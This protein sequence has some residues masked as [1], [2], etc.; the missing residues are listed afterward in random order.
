MPSSNRSGTSSDDGSSFTGARVSSQ[1]GRGGQDTAVRPRN[2]YGEQVKKSASQR[3]DVDRRVCGQVHAVHCQ[4]RPP[5]APARRCGPRAARVPIRLEAPVTATSFV[6]SVSTS[7]T[8]LAVSSR[9]AGLKAARSGSDRLGGAHPG[10]TVVV[11]A[12]NRRLRRPDPGPPRP[13]CGRGRRVAG[14]RSRRRRRRADR[15]PAGRRP[16]TAPEDDVVGQLGGGDPA[17]VGDRR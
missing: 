14:W 9:V 8:S 5:G 7:A 11:P 15:R 1:A 13:A 17:A 2:L 6:R 16:R 10:G 12:G 3:P 4:Q